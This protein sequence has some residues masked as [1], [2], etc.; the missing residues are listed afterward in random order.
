MR[1]QIPA[2]RIQIS[3]RYQDSASTCSLYCHIYSKEDI[4]TYMYNVHYTLY[5]IHYTLYL[6]ENISGRYDRIIEKGNGLMVNGHAMEGCVNGSDRYV[7][8]YFDSQQSYCSRRYL[9]LSWCVHLLLELT[10]DQ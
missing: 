1:L 9:L 2:L 5:I 7:N 3:H 4:N 8:N 6:L 10:C